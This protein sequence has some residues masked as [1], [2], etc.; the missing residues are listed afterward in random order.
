M[1]RWVSVWRQRGRQVDNIISA[2]KPRS[3]YFWRI[4]AVLRNATGTAKAYR[5]ARISRTTPIEICAFHSTHA[6]RSLPITA[7]LARQVPDLAVPIAY[8]QVLFLYLHNRLE[9]AHSPS[10]QVVA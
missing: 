2:T 5:N 3:T 4:L 6:R 8:C 10:C 9:K 1:L 7:M